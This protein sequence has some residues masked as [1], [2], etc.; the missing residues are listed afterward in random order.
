MSL[1]PQH[2]S[3]DEVPILSSQS[4]EM[5]ASPGCPWLV[6]NYGSRVGK[7][8]MDYDDGELRFQVAHVLTDSVMD[9]RLLL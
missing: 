2:T 5:Y 3:A 4:P 7:F 8:E 6:F 1:M 9:D